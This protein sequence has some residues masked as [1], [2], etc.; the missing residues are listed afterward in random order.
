MI[1]CGWIVID[2]NYPN[3]LVC[4]RCGT[5]QAIPLPL[6]ISMYVAF[7]NSFKEIHKHCQKEEE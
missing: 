6:P 2:L 1:K 3:A 4:K 5:R 7:A